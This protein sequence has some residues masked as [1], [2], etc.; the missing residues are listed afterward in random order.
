MLRLHLPPVGR[1]GGLSH[2][3]VVGGLCHLTKNG[4]RARAFLF[5]PSFGV[6]RPVHGR[7]IEQDLV[8]SRVERLDGEHGGGRIHTQSHSS[9]NQPAEIMS[10]SPIWDAV[11]Q[12][13]ELVS[14]PTLKA[15]Q[16]LTK[17]QPGTVSILSTHASVAAAM[18]AYLAIIFGGQILM[19]DQKPMR[20]PPSALVHTLVHRRP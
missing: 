8:H 2:R 15:T 19:N 14:P 3:R 13:A 17:W 11:A 20:T 1:I 4:R 10:P 5:R 16:A 12:L 18:V 7:G 9:P 6:E